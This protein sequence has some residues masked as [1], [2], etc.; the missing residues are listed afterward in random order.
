MGLASLLG[1][2]LEIAADIFSQNLLSDL[3]QH[4]CFEFFFIEQ[5]GIASHPPFLQVRA[6]GM[7]VVLS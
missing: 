5:R 7:V 6:A 2:K 4:R 1:N 3:V